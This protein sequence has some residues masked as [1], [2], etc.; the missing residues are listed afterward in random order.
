MVTLQ[1]NLIYQENAELHKKVTLLSE[2]NMELHEKVGL[3]K[4]ISIRSLS[5]VCCL[6]QAKNS[7]R[8]HQVKA[9]RGEI[10][11]SGDSAVPYGCLSIREEA[12]APNHL[13]L[14]RPLEQA[15]GVQIGAPQL[16]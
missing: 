5:G 15:N 3:R 12:D 1:A 8:L 4:L 9:T 11:D 13:Q 7:N 16:R 14:S 6:T 2:E 10:G